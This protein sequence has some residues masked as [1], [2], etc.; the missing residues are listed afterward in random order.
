MRHYKFNCV[1]ISPSGAPGPD[2][3]SVQIVELAVGSESPNGTTSDANFI[4][5]VAIT[6]VLH[7]CQNAEFRYV[8]LKSSKYFIN[9][10]RI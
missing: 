4:C 8:L 2:P 3:Q 9:K 10:I 5:A 1:G 6:F 7:L